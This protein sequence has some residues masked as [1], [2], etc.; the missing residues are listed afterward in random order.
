MPTILGS[1]AAVEQGYRF[2]WSP[3]RGLVSVRTWKG[4]ADA[5]LALLPTITFSGASVDGRQLPGG[6]YELEATYGGDQ[7]NNFP[8][9]EIVDNWE[10]LP[11]VVL[12]GLLSHD[13]SII[14]SLNSKDIE[15]IQYWI[16]NPPTKDVTPDFSTGGNP[17]NATKVY[18]LM[19]ADVTHA[20]VVQPI[21]RHTYIVPSGTNTSYVFTNSQKVLTTSQLISTEGVPSDFLLPLS[22]LPTVFANPTRS[23]GLTTSLQY[24]W[25]KRMP[26]LSVAA[27][28][29]REV[30]LEWVFGLWSTDLYTF[31]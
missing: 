7:N 6:L 1:Q 21:M 10:L 24:G 22:Q 25:L 28:R 19:K 5:I 29:R 18:A 14:N 15:N 12:K 30:Y 2:S 3:T 20:E 13:C 8:G 17:T 26:T 4:K 23:D 31:A 11:N 9:T 27:Y 16:T